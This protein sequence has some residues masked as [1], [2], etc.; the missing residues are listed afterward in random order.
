MN[1]R[2]LCEGLDGA[3]RLSQR[4]QLERLQEH[5]RLQQTACEKTTWSSDQF[6]A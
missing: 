5:A 3:E 4:E 1:I 2:V 6:M